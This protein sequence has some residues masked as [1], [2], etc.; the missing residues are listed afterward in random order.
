MWVSI[1]FRPWT[2]LFRAA[3]PDSD[4]TVC[5]LN[6]D[7]NENPLP[8]TASDST[9]N[10]GKPAENYLHMFLAPE[11]TNQPVNIFSTGR[12]E[13]NKNHDSCKYS[14]SSGRGAYY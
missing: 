5:G 1:K 7:N 9:E 11:S 12:S 6:L 4:A 3:V 8:S 13:K 14:Y 2:L 10:T